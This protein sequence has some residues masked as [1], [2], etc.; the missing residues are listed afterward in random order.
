MGYAYCCRVAEVAACRTALSLIEVIEEPEGRAVRAHDGHTHAVGER[1]SDR[2][3]MLALAGE[4]DISNRENESVMHGG[5]NVHLHHAA[6]K[7]VRDQNQPN[8]II[9]TRRELLN[10]I[11]IVHDAA[12]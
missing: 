2:A 10:L 6:R 9:K 7:S 5:E 11:V 1:N 8:S 4:R 12:I 3:N